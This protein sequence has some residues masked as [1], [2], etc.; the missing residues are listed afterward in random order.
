M[1]REREVLEIKMCAAVNFLPEAERFKF[2]KGFTHTHTHQ[3]LFSV[4]KIKGCPNKKATY[5]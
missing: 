1:L 3:E 4:Q 5:N 2:L